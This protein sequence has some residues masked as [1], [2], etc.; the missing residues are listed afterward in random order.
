[1]S[2]IIIYIDEAG[3]PGAHSEPIVAASGETPLFCLVGLALPLSDWR[4]RDRDYLRLKRQF[5][6]D[7]MARTNKR[8]EEF[9]IKGNE[10]TSP[11]QRTSS[12][13]QAFNK[14]VLSYIQQSGGAAFSATFLKSCH[15]PVSPRSIY[16]KALQILVE[17]ISLYIAEHTSYDNAILI[18]DSRM[19]G[20]DTN[21]ARSHMS[22]IFGHQTGRTFTNIIEAPLFAD[23]RLTVGLQLVD[24]LASNIYANHYYYYCRNVPGAIDY[25]HSHAY[26]PILNALQFQS[27]GQ[28]DGHNIHGYRIIDHRDGN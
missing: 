10:L 12:R 14:R 15:D 17:R 4:M 24:I 1:M 20:L 21:V 11:R 23:S 22:Y 18:C 7:D 26:W 27:T 19:K 28:I 8:H 9:E 2:T 3:N 5:F 13:R 6:P 25:S 16:T